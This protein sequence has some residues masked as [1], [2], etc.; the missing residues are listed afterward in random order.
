MNSSPPK[1]RESFWTGPV[2][3]T[4]DDLL[5]SYSTP[6][7]GDP[8]KPKRPRE[9]VQPAPPPFVAQ[10]TVPFATSASLQASSPAELQPLATAAKMAAASGANAPVAP[11]VPVAANGLQDPR[12]LALLEQLLPT[13]TGQSTG[14]FD[15]N[16]LDLSQAQ[17][18]LPAIETLAKFYGIGLAP[19]ASLSAGI[20]L[21]AA[22]GE[23]ESAST[24]P[25][26]PQ[27]EGVAS[28]SSSTAATAPSSRRAT[29][30]A[31]E[32]FVVID[33]SN[34]TALQKE[35]VGKQNPRD[36]RGGCANCKR[37]KSTTWHEGRDKLGTLTSV[38]NGELPWAAYLQLF[39]HSR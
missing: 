7:G 11:A 34:M 24:R 10:T 36:P 4:G 22:S 17:A 23:A 2:V 25:E 30:Q 16:G 1:R 14:S 18:L 12:M 9:R 31:T 6:G 3:A 27:A 13:L 38:C 33:V 5:P 29:V 35:Q 28:V 15:S 21:P 32:R 19:P 37:R 26:A 20:P 8:V 39:L